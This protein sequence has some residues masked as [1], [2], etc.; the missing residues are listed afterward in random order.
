MTTRTLQTVLLA[1]LT[2]TIVACGGASIRFS[3]RVIPGPVG[4]AAVVPVDD[5]RLSEPGLAGINVTLLKATS[6]RGGSL[7]AQVVT[8]DLG[9]F[10][11]VLGRGQH[12]GGPII[13]RVQGEDVFD[14]RSKAYLPGSGQSL[15]CT[16]MQREP[17]KDP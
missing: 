2:L 13:V 3:G 11:I 16:V 10:E 14:A 12:P 15:L 7:V 8:D 1:A 6:A 4:V 17:R 5:A 9:D